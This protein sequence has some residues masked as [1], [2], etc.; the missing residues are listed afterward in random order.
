[1]LFADGSV[2]LIDE[3]IEIQVLASLMTREGREVLKTSSY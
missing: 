2:K 3:D 1:M